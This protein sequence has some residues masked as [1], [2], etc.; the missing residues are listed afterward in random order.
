MAKAKQQS[1]RTPPAASATGPRFNWALALIAGG[2]AAAAVVVV[3]VIMQARGG[4]SGDIDGARAAEADAS[5]EIPGNFVNLP[6]IYGGPYKDTAQHVTRQVDYAA[7]C[8]PT[9]P[10]VCNTIPPVGG[11][12]WSGS[13]GSDPASAPSFCGPAPWGVYREEW[14]AETLV[15]NMEHAGV[16]L[17]YNTDDQQV[18]DELEA[19]VLE[20]GGNLVMAPYSELEEETIAL[21]SWS[22]LESFPVAEYTMERV[23]AFLDVNYKRFNP[24]GF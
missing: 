10:E 4:N 18:I 21:T 20:R 6:E 1:R 3:F 9:D 7:D 24:E 23:E 16:V 11:P 15:H 8:S 5:A 14:D 19:Y 2:I 13:C 12:H 22:R 17:W